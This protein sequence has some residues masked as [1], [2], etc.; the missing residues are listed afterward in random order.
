M[1]LGTL[2]EDIRELSS[3][4]SPV[5]STTTIIIAVVSGEVES[6]SIVSKEVLSRCAYCCSGRG[7]ESL[8]KKGVG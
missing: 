6:L 5:D 4:D 2:A 7:Y 1:Y 8:R 3:G